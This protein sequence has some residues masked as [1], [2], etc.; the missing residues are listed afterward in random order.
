MTILCIVLGHT[1]SS[2]RRHNQG[3]DF[4]LCHHCGCDLIRAADEGEWGEVPKGYKVAWR[5]R[6][7]TGDAAAVSVRMQ[8]PPPPR[9][10]DPR[11]ARPAR[12]RD[13]RGRVFGG[14]ASLVSMFA[15]L[16]ELIGETERK[17]DLIALPTSKTIR[18]PAA[19]A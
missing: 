15:N 6:P 1:A 4:T 17:D 10:R 8:N 2:S 13:P 11:S 19:N 14:T 16:G 18:L 3:F 12:R 9:R 5:S 7:R